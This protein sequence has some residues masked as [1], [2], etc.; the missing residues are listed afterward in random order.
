MFHDRE[1]YSN[2]S[3]EYICFLRLPSL[4]TYTNQSSPTYPRDLADSYFKAVIYDSLN[5]LEIVHNEF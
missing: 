5:R 3:K 1:F 2:K 4:S